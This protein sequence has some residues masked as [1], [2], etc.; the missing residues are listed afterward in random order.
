[1]E[2]HKQIIVLIEDEEMM[3]EVEEKMRREELMEDFTNDYLANVR[4]IMTH[5]EVVKMFYSGQHQT[6]N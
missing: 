3:E 5:S 4:K 6:L 1:M 2:T